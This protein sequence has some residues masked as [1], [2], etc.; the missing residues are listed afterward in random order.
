MTPDQ[1]PPVDPA[2]L[3]AAAE[4]AIL[5]RFP[6]YREIEVGEIIQKGDRV[7]RL[8]GTIEESFPTRCAGEALELVGA[9][10]YFRR[11]DPV[12]HTDPTDCPD[13]G[14]NEA[15]DDGDLCARH[16]KEACKLADS[17]AAPEGNSQKAPA[18]SLRALLNKLEY[19]AIRESNYEGSN[20]KRMS[21]LLELARAEVMELFSDQSAQISTLTDALSAYREVM[22]VL[23]RQGMCLGNYWISWSALENDNPVFA[24]NIQEWR[25]KVAALLESPALVQALK[26]GG[27]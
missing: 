12:P 7:L 21:A 14:A 23:D 20:T 19:A 4:T 27:A 5:P 25:D 3:A 1:N 16:Y 22:P 17:L 26:G 24:K 18:P 9:G 11:I 6:G 8:D 15:Q 2:A 10:R 13:C